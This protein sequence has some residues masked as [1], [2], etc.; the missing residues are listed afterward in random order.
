MRTRLFALTAL[1]IVSAACDK[2]DKGSGY[3]GPVAAEIIA[4]I[5]TATRMSGT[6]WEEGDRIGIFCF[7]GKYAD[8]PYKMTDGKFTPEEETI[9]LQ[10]SEDVTFSAYFPYGSGEST[11]RTDADNQGPGIDFLFASGATANALD[12][13]VNF[14]DKNA[15]DEYDP[16]KDHSFHHCMSLLKFRFKPGDGVD[17][18]L[19]TPSSYSLYPVVLEGYFDKY[20]GE[21]ELYDDSV[22]EITMPLDGLESQIILFPQQVSGLSLT[23]RYN[24]VNYMVDLPSPQN[25]M[26]EA[27]YS[28]TYNV[29][30]NNS[31]IKLETSSIVGWE[32]AG[33]DN[34]SVLL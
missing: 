14:T 31:G 7:S 16:E 28:Y 23:V 18:S 34:P 17:F 27:G 11:V 3:E 22:E 32:T 20:T 21:T 2:G 9:Y 30:V 8:I 1:A 24:D 6:S 4:D 12:P 25:G 19:S 5:G 29:R 26:L 33:T 13:T 15:D 10:D